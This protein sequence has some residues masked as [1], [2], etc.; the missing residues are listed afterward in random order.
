MS[1]LCIVTLVAVLCLVASSAAAS[2]A[3]NDDSCDITVA[4]AATLLLP[5]FDVDV[6]QPGAETTLFTITNVTSAPQI[7]HVTIWT[8]WAYPL[9]TFNLFLTGYDVQ[10]VN[11][12][13]VIVRG[14]VAPGNQAATSPRLIAGPGSQPG[15]DESNPNLSREACPGTT[16]KPELVEAV[17]WA[18]RTGLYN[19]GS[20]TVCG[21][22]RVGGTHTN[23]RGYLTIDVVAS[24]SSLLPTNPAYYSMQILFDNALIGDYQQLSGDSLASATPMVHIRAIPEGGPAGFVPEGTTSLPYTFY[25][26]YT[27]ATNR[28]IDRRVP[29]PSAFAVRWIDNR[30]GGMETR[31][32]IWREGWVSGEDA[33]TCTGVV[34]NFYTTLTEIIR[35]DEHENSFA[36]TAAVSC[37]PYCHLLYP[38]SSASFLVRSSDVTFFPG[39]AGSP[40][41][42]GWLYLNLN[43]Q[44]PAPFSLPPRPP[45]YEPARPSQNWVTAVM[46]A[47]GRYAVEF[48]GAQLGNGCSPG[49][50][51]PS[52]QIGPAAGGTNATP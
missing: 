41:I 52:R 38:S 5:F 31:Y 22:R 12:Y 50:G 2:T 40:D 33:K 11:L 4:P 20:T 25:D 44:P 42:A 29:L 28:K 26:R 14:V 23:A 45:P 21:T 13:D 36:N 49:F 15:I 32:K 43:N 19:V 37:A 39:N 46:Y 16:L 24:C 18:L 47:Q 48:D 7:A 1:R 51:Y 35:F 27:P 17:Q 3:N 8:D 30:A 34:P 10:S 6:T 9:L